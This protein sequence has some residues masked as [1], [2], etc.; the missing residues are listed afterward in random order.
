MLTRGKPC[1]GSEGVLNKLLRVSPAPPPSRRVSPLQPFAVILTLTHIYT[2]FV[3]LPVY[4]AMEHIPRRLL[5]ASQDLGA[6]PARVFWTV[7]FPL[8][9][10]GV[11]AGA[12]FAFVLSLGD[13]LAP[14]LIGGPSGI[15]ISNVVVSLF[16]A[17]YDWPLG[18]AMSFVML[19]FVV[20]LISA[21]ERASGA[22]ARTDD[23]NA[24]R[25]GLVGYSCRAGLR[26]PVPADRHPRHLLVQW[27]KRRRVPARAAG[28]SSGIACMLQDDALLAA[29]GNSLLVAL[30]AVVI[31]VSLGL[32]AALALDRAAFPGKALFRRLV[33]LPLI[34]P[35][36]ITGLSLLIFLS[37]MG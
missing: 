5:E 18:A 35:G 25:T 4:A 16:G 37:A 31:S 1:S 15:M 8:A 22:G 12:T 36:I 29:V 33:L 26:V 19:V 34:L 21:T 13:F 27:R 14:L 20:V 2:P 3:F 11:L 24:S 23:D 10:P 32:P 9:L 30:L 28:P 6:S 17:A 7:V